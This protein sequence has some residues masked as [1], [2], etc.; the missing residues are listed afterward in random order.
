LLK[1]Y[2]CITTH[3]FLCFRLCRWFRWSKRETTRPVFVC[4]FVWG[5]RYG[6]QFCSAF[7]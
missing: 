4:C 5:R 3:N 6:S 2:F 1:C 7:L